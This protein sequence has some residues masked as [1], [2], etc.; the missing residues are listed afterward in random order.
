MGGIVYS[1]SHPENLLDAVIIKVDSLGVL[2][3]L[4][5]NNQIF[6]HEAIVYPNPGT[7]Y[8]I[9]QSGPQING[10]LFTLCDTQGKQLLKTNLYSP[11]ENIP[12][13]NVSSGAYPLEGDV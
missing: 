9:V 7:D 1:P 12:V 11:M 5:N 3:G 6:T 10:A 4:N 13:P 8:L 2:T